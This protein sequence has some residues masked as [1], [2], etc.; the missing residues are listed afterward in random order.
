MKILITG[1]QGFIGSNLVKKMD[2]LG[3]EILQFDK[4]NGVDITNWKEVMRTPKFN[5]LIHLAARSY[6]PD[7]RVNPRDYYTTN[8]LGTLNSLELCRMHSAR[9][10]FN[11]SYLY[12]DPIYLPIDEN[13]PISTLNP[14]SHSK[15]IGEQLCES[16]NKEFGVPV[17]ILRLFNI[18]GIAQSSKF[19][20]PSIMSQVKSG[21]VELEN[22]F[23][24]RDFVYIDDLI[25]VYIK[26][27]E[28]SDFVYEIFNI[29]SGSN[30]SVDEIASIINSLHNNKLKII[31]RSIIRD[32]EIH[33]TLA[34]IS[35]VKKMLNWSPKTT[36]YKGLQKIIENK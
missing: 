32:K 28:R 10:I 16:Y 33:E 2:S 13:H 27:I 21:I 29:G 8:I 30:Y 17:V 31:Y 15:M 20:I 5:I 36:L 22:P 35:K 14:Y 23:P 26:L 11:S 34:D 12:G 1:S 7:S 18:Y 3:I 9:I 25:E 19:L 4:Y 6:I 24:R